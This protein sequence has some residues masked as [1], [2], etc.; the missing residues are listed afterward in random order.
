MAT[1]CTLVYRH[2]TN[3]TESIGASGSHIIDIRCANSQYVDQ[4]QQQPLNESRDLFEDAAA[5]RLPTDEMFFIGFF[6]L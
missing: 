4:Q 5:L 3:T 2:T 1:E 6:I